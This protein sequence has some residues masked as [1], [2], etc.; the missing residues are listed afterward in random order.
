MLH[1]DLDDAIRITNRRRILRVGRPYVDR[2]DGTP[3]GMLFM[4]LNADIE[5]QFELV[6]QAWMQNADFDG[7]R[8]ETDPLLGRRNGGAPRSFTIPTRHGP[9]CLKNLPD[10]VSV[11]GGGYFWMPSRAAVDF[12]AHAPADAAVAGPGTPAPSAPKAA[13]IATPERQPASVGE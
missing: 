1:P 12:L 2:P 13:A 9:V 4:C 11:V 5:R 6:Q 7:L 10:F 8:D 3:Q